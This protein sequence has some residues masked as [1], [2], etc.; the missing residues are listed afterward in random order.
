VI[1]DPLTCASSHAGTRRES[2]GDRLRPR[3]GRRA[4]RRRPLL[5]PTHEL[6]RPGRSVGLRRTSIVRSG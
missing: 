6:T 4:S 2:P 3:A 1:E 5:N